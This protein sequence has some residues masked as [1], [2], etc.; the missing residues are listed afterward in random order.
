MHGEEHQQGGC[1]GGH[2]VPQIEQLEHQE[3][4][5]G[6][7]GAEQR[8]VA[9]PVRCFGG[10]GGGG[11]RLHIRDQGRHQVGDEHRQDAG[12]EVA[13]D[14]IVQ[15]GLGVAGKVQHDAEAEH[16]IGAEQE[17]TAPGHGGE[18][19]EKQQEDD[20]QH[21]A[22][23]ATEQAAKQPDFQPA[24]G[25]GGDELAGGVAVHHGD[26]PQ[27][28]HR[29]DGEEDPVAPAEDL[30]QHK[31]QGAAKGDAQA[32]AQL[33]GGEGSVPQVHGRHLNRCSASG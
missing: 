18:A 17:E 19:V 27:Q 21:Q 22:G 13:E 28:Q 1:L 2:G 23:M 6:D 12:P 20:G 4:Q 15:I 11:P 32:L 10:R 7:A 5:G 26:H 9:H 25:G 31:S 24:H 29:G 8:L 30:A 3:R 16:A 14:E 33:V